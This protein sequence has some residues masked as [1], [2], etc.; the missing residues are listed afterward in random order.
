MPLY[1]KGQFP[2]INEEALLSENQTFDLDLNALPV[3]EMD[4]IENIIFEKNKDLKML[5]SMKTFD[6]RRSGKGPQKRL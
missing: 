4:E 1:Q 3:D 6:F 2:K 5:K